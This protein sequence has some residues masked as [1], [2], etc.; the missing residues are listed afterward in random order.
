MGLVPG[1]QFG[2][3]A[4][5]LGQQGG[6]LRRQVADDGVETG[7]EIGAVHAG[8]GQ[9]LV[10]DE[11]VQDGRDLKAVDLGAHDGDLVKM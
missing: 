7:P 9:D 4:V 1:I 3:Q 5:P 10:L 8:A 11:A 2:L 6:V